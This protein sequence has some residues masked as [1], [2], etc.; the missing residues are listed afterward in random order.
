MIALLRN[1][2]FALLWLANFISFV[3]DTA[4]SIALPLH[5]Y[6]LTGSTLSTAAAFAASTLPRVLLGSVAGIFVDRWDRKRVMIVTDLARA[7]LLLAI[8]ATPDQLAVLYAVGVL[9]GTLGLF[10]GPAEGALLPKLV[11]DER[12]VS[13]NALNALTI[14]VGLLLGPAVGTL[15]YTTLGIGGTVL[16][17][18]ASYVVSAVLVSLIAADGRPERVVDALAGGAAWV[19][20]LADWR[21][22]LRVVWSDLSLRVLLVSSMLGN[23]ANG[24]FLT[25]GLSP[26]VLDVLGGTSAQVGWVASAG[27]VGG[28]VAGVVIVRVGPRLSRRWLYGGGL[29]GIGLA[30]LGA[31]N[32]RRV[33]SA[34]TPA[35]GV[36]MGWMAIGGVPDVM[37]WA[38]RQTLMQAQTT[39]AYRG[40]VF[41]ALGSANSVAL[42]AGLVAGGVLG[43]AAG[44]VPVLSAAALVRILGGLMAVALLPRHE[45]GPAAVVDDG[46]LSR[47]SSSQQPVA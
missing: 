10:F 44:I 33:A 9:Q 40:R 24:V 29:A 13:A 32:A 16:V 39:D 14:S 12:L 25:L 15:C 30:D 38:G 36:A 45:H 8:V 5:V 37:S 42:L 4:L 2:D 35:V 3:G 11:G 46:A 7:V 27:A 20:M 6:R 31:A 19:G 23:V 41:G 43:D 34:G 26:L 17:D 18:A 1:R 21:A 22:G 47:E 28:L